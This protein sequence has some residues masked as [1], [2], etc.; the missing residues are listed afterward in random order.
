[1]DNNDSFISEI[2]RKHRSKRRKKKVIINDS[3]GKLF[4]IYDKT[5]ST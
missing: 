5:T 1:M 4:I 3:S 2:G